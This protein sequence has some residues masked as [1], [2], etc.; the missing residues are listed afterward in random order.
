MRTLK[1]A[2]LAFFVGAGLGTGA[3]SIFG[4]KLIAWYF[5]PPVSIGVSCQE[6]A[7]WAVNR[8]QNLQLLMLIVSGVFCSLLVFAFRS[9]KT[10]QAS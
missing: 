5:E 8:F 3:A 2:I 6:A 7:V 1:R 4:P 9:K 10:P